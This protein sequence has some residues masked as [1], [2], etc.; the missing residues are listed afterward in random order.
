M[1]I[2]TLDFERMQARCNARR[3]HAVTPDAVECE[4]GLHEAIISECRARL[5]P[6]IHSRMDAKTTTAKGA[7]DFTIFADGGRVFSIECKSKTGKQT[8]EQIGWQMLLE[9]NG[10]AYRVVRSLTEFLDLVKTP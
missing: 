3:G 4:A 9:R 2:S 1:A 7:P 6:V 8:P 5:W 10:H